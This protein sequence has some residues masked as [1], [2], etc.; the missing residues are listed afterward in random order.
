MTI[1]CSNLVHFRFTENYHRDWY[2]I[3]E[4]SRLV[5]G[6]SIEGNSW[7]S[8]GANRSRAGHTNRSKSSSLTAVMISCTIWYTIQSR[9][10]LFPHVNNAFTELK[11]S[12]SFELCSWALPLRLNHRR[13]V[14]W[15]DFVL[16][17][18]IVKSNFHHFTHV[19]YHL[20]WEHSECCAI[21]PIGIWSH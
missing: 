19:K 14:S 5:T 17:R 9:R 4:R 1:V 3:S 21:E 18:V 6:I 13:Q 2:L 12:S 10:F 8:M 7:L 15:V 16:W 11:E 20:T